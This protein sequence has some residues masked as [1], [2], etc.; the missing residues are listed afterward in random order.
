M[1]LRSPALTLTN[2]KHRIAVDFTGPWFSAHLGNDEIND[3]RAQRAS[4]GNKTKRQDYDDQH[5][6]DEAGVDEEG[7]ASL[8][9]VG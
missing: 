2:G 8:S 9:R 5:Y 6:R 7:C 3:S 1:R 4:T